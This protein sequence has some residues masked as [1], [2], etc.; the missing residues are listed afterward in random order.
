MNEVE[1][2]NA[3]LGSHFHF[4]HASCTRTWKGSRAICTQDVGSK[5]SCPNGLSHWYQDRA[6]ASISRQLRIPRISCVADHRSCTPRDSHHCIFE[7]PAASEKCIRPESHSQAG[8]PAKLA[9]GCT[10]ES[11][12]CCVDMEMA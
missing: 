5:S 1:S 11:H 10:Q 8:I 7:G 3:E 6:E 2:W 4:C 9:A 12:W